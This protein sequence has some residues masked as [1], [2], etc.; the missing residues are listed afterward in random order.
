MSADV[1]G[2][3]FGGAAGQAVHV[4]MLGN[5]VTPVPG[6]LKSLGDPNRAGDG[7]GGALTVLDPHEVKH[8]KRQ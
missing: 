5:P 1:R 7:I 8:G 4:V 6:I 3:Q 2:E